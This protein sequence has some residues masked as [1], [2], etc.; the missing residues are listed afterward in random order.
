LAAYIIESFSIKISE[1]DRVRKDD[2]NY[3]LRNKQTEEDSIGDKFGWSHSFPYQK[4]GIMS[5]MKHQREKLRTH[6]ELEVISIIILEFLSKPK[7]PLKAAL[8]QGASPLGEYIR[9]T[10]QLFL[11][12]INERTGFKFTGSG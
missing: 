4:T 12:H 6:Y 2:Y 1:I 10:L 9:V 11:T 7:Y 8:N 5:Q 3:I